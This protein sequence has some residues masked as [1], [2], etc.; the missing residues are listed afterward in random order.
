V[1]EFEP[2]G[3]SAVIVLRLLAPIAMIAAL[4]ARADA[5]PPAVALTGDAGLVESVGG[6]LAARGIAAATPACPAVH[7]RLARDGA[8]VVVGIE[9]TGDAPVERRVSEAATAATVIESWTRTDDEASL[10]A[11]HAVAVEEHETIAPPVATSTPTVRGVQLFANAVAARASDDTDWGGVQL[12]MCINLGA[13]CAATRLRF[14]RVLHGPGVWSTGVHRESVELMVGLDVPIELG[15]F[16]LTPGFAAGMGKMHTGSDD[17]P[18][19]ETA[20]LRAD[21]HATLTIPI[22]HRWSIDVSLTGDLTQK[23]HVETQQGMTLP[24]E[25]RG[26]VWGG[27]GVR[28]GG[29]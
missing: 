15:R 13:L 5:C 11:P 27:V 14:S 9:R 1:K 18:H 20:G 16:V 23:V 17:M 21:I 25:P 3:H 7:A 22:T 26:L 28:Y 12:G 19:G 10:L 6:L 4:A 24:D 29:L 8:A 2:G